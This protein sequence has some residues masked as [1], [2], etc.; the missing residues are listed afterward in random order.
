LTQSEFDLSFLQAKPDRN[1]LKSDS[2]FV[3][4]AA[5]SEFH[6]MIHTNFDLLSHIKPNT[7]CFILQ[8]WV[9]RGIFF[10]AQSNLEQNPSTRNPVPL[11][12]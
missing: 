8:T 7:G 12:K 3:G 5:S 2:D 6:S 9:E 11:R 10:H 4:E 1:G